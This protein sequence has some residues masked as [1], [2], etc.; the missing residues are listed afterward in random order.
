[1]AKTVTVSEKGQVVIPAEIRRRLGIVAG[2]QLEFVEEG[3]SLRVLVKRARKPTL[4][5]DGY[6]ML[7]A[8]AGPPRRLEDFD[9]VDAMRRG[10]KP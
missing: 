10:S 6:G 7:T 4:H 9:V 5:E 3:A 1:M 8:P 2:S